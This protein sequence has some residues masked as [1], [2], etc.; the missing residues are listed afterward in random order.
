MSELEVLNLV[1]QSQE[2]LIIDHVSFHIADGEFFVLLGPSGSGKSTLIRL[3]CGFET[4]DAGQIILNGQEIT[5]QLNHHRNLAV[6][7]QDYGL[8]ESMNVFDNIAYSLQNQHMPRKEIE[9]RILMASEVLELKSLLKRALTDLS[10]GEVQRVA[11]AKVLVKDADLY[12]FDEPLSQLDQ[13]ARYRIRQEIMMI[14]HL[15]R[16][17][18]LYITHD[19]NEAFAMADRI[20]VIS[21]GKIQQIGTPEEVRNRP[22]TLFVAKFLSDPPINLLE[23]YLQYHDVRYHMTTDG[24]QLILPTR[25]TNGLARLGPQSKISLGLRPTGLIPQWDLPTL[26]GVPHVRAQT[27]VMA[28][29]PMIGRVLVQLKLGFHTLLTAEFDDDHPQA[30]YIGAMLIIGIKMEEFLLFHPTSGELLN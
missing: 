6:V 10:G 23:S 18:T 20:A 12:L 7:F 24:L 25:W 14:H 22:K 1:K 13:K 5:N 17:P 19:Q 16:K 8:F 3:L 26:E 30:L 9:M 2:Q 4:P 15:K 11:L 29:E 28:V 21:D 27:Q